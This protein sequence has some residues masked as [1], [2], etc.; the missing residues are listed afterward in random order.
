[1]GGIVGGVVGLEV[2]VWHVL[3]RASHPQHW[4]PHAHPKNKSTN[5]SKVQWR[6]QQHPGDRCVLL[7]MIGE[8]V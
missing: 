6:S 3:R 5:I 2:R 8:P 4:I 7:S 1:M